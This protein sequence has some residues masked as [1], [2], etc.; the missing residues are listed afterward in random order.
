[1][2]FCLKSFK[3]SS[4]VLKMTF[5]LLLLLV[6]T[7]SGYTDAWESKSKLL[8][9]SDFQNVLLECVSW[10]F[11][12]F[13]KSLCEKSPLSRDLFLKACCF[14]LNWYAYISDI[15]SDELTFG[16][17]SLSRYVAFA[18]EKCSASQS[19]SLRYP[20]NQETS[21]WEQILSAAVWILLPPLLRRHSSYIAPWAM[22]SN[23]DSF[24]SKD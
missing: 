21:L 11:S 12:S 17:C 10:V 16:L 13:E 24:A 6:N 23:S 4:L 18:L 5:L 3:V 1:M 8:M 14:A 15:S 2:S 20:V 9:Y 19:C 7:V 22:L